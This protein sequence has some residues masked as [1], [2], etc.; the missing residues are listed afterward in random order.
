MLLLFHKIILFIH[1]LTKNDDEC[2]LF[3]FTSK[4]YMS[5]S[6]SLERP[7][8]NYLN[9]QKRNDTFISLSVCSTVLLV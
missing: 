3:F 8:N 7:T 9:G 6:I 4:K 5:M 1:D 2:I